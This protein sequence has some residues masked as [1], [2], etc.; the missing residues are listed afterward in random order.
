MYR[1]WDI[2]TKMT[3]GGA[4]SFTYLLL[5]P[6]KVFFVNQWPGLIL[7][8]TNSWPLIRENLVPSD[9]LITFLIS[10]FFCFLAACL[11]SPLSQELSHSSPFSSQTSLLASITRS[12]CWAGLKDRSRPISRIHFLSM[13]SPG[14]GVL[15]STS[16]GNT[17]WESPW[18]V[19]GVQIA[20]TWLAYIFAKFACK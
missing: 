9:S 15:I 5:S 3:D 14:S 1:L 2:K 18:A 20:C 19:L 17:I 7:L 10:R 16:T 4:R 8:F 11:S 6:I 12:T 13:N